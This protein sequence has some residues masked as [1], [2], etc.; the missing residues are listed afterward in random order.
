MHRPN[1]PYKTAGILLCN[2]GGSVL[3]HSAARRA[4]GRCRMPE[5][6]GR[7]T[8]LVIESRRIMPTEL[9]L[10]VILTTYERPRH[11]ERSLAS[12]ARPAQHGGPL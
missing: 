2:F 12:L 4:S 5:R 3:L 1:R 10:S 8:T 6:A 11:L 7:M 9:E